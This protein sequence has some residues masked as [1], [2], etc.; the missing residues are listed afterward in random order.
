MAV[1]SER[2]HPERV[3]TVE[4]TLMK[5]KHEYAY[6]LAAALIPRGAA[7]LEVGF[8]EGYGTQLLGDRFASYDGLELDGEV[9]EHAR[10]RYTDPALAFREYDGVVFPYADASFDVVLSF[11]V[12]EHVVD[13]GAWLAQIRRVCRAGALV[14][15][16]TPNRRGRVADGERPWNRYH[17]REFT[18]AELDQALAPHFRDVEIEGIYGTA[19]LEELERDRVAR[20]RKIA[21]VDRLGLRYLLPEL[22]V[23]R[24]GN[25]VRGGRQL[26]GRE[27]DQ[28]GFT[29]ADYARSSTR[30][31]DGIDL[32]ALAR[33]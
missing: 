9:V 15:L 4:D 23:A 26:S 19:A 11:Q 30:A 10:S 25:I 29:T 17:V 18:D 27:N 33:V 8:G 13:V 31:G 32:L 16:T 28:P 12:I 2:Q 24:L 3:F 5:A 1:T 20:M 22:F 7:V 14:V 6:E 21:R